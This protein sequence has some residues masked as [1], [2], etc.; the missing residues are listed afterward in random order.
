MSG[1]IANANSSLRSLESQVLLS[2]QLDN[3][4]ADSNGMSETESLKAHAPCGGG[5]TAAS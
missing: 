5:E 4:M 2:A 3:W 1:G